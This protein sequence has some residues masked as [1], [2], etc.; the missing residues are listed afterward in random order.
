MDITPE[1]VKLKLREWDKEVE[2]YKLIRSARERV[3]SRRGFL[4][5][6]GNIL[7]VCGQRI[8]GLKK[9]PSQPLPA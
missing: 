3:D 8:A 1:E 2:R 7:R 6:V 5:T 4:P 9:T